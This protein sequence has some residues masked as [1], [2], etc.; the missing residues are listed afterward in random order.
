MEQIATSDSQKLACPLESRLLSA[1]ELFG[2]VDAGMTQQLLH[3]TQVFAIIEQASGVRAAQIMRGE[4]LEFGLILT[5]FEDV[6]D[7]LVTQPL[8]GIVLVTPN[9][10]EERAW[11]NAARLLNPMTQVLLS[12]HRHK[13]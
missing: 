12:L 8:A 4:I 10:G 3:C 1:L 11:V 7:R 2:S 9:A 5:G 13:H 6:I